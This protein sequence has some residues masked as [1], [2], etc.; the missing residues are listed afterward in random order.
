MGPFQ[1]TQTGGN[2]LSCAG[3]RT[4]GR[5]N[6]GRHSGRKGL[7]IALQAPVKAA[8]PIT[9]D[10]QKRNGGIVLMA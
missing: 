8:G 1:L 3:R 7:T 9:A 5:K 6:A 10:S 2:D 4:V